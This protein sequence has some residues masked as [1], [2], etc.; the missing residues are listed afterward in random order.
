MKIKHITKNKDTITVDTE[1]WAL[2][3]FDTT[4][5]DG[6]PIII[7]IVKTKDGNFTNFISVWNKQNIDESKLEEFQ[8]IRVT[9]ITHTAKNNNEYKNFTKIELI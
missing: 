6:K 1:L 9:Y 5:K 8:P 7:M 2:E 3:T 4:T